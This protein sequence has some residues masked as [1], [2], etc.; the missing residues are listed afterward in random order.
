M[1]RLQV[2]STGPGAAPDAVLLDPAA[3]SGQALRVL[4][5]MCRIVGQ[6]ATIDLELSLRWDCLVACTPQFSNW[7]RAQKPERPPPAPQ[8]FLEVMR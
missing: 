3:L 2:I 6:G 1:S 4:L 8:F 5:L 7:W